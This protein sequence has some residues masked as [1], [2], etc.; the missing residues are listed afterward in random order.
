[1][2]WPV[3]GHLVVTI[4]LFTPRSHETHTC[5]REY[6]TQ[7]LESSFAKIV[8]KMHVRKLPPGPS[9]GITSFIVSVFWSIFFFK[10]AIVKDRSFESKRKGAAERE[11]NRG[12][13]TRR[14]PPP[15]RAW[16]RGSGPFHSAPWGAVNQRPRWGEQ[17][18]GVTRNSRE[19]LE[20]GRGHKAVVPQTFWH[21]GPVSWKTIFPGTLGLGV[22]WGMIPAHYI[23]CAFC[24]YYYYYISSTS[25]HQTLDPRIW[26][27]WHK[28]CRFLQSKP[29]SPSGARL[30]PRGGGL[31]A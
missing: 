29:G 2:S 28:R 19:P 24:F 31:W 30:Y 10:D 13:N 26:D 3:P 20:G 7:M 18:L 21:Q 14:G 25:D 23:Y 1:M 12:S 8:R 27:P 6:L 15:T 4:L 9:V 17:E 16:V 11:E 22:I 5:G